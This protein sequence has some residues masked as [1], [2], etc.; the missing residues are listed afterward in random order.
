[1]DCAQN[2]DSVSA[3][4]NVIP[5][6]LA[7]SLM[8]GIAKAFD[9][10]IP[11]IAHHGDDVAIGGEHVLKALYGDAFTGGC[12]K[13]NARWRWDECRL[14]I[15]TQLMNVSLGRLQV[16]S[17]T[18]LARCRN[19]EVDAL[20]ADVFVQLTGESLKNVTSRD[21]CFPSAG[22]KNATRNTIFNHPKDKRSHELIF[23]SG[24]AR[25]RGG[26]L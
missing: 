24:E 2:A 6:E 5:R 12:G 26:R 3:F 9:A 16:G 1:M 8:C 17:H 19:T 20:C 21:S 18:A 22:Y 23:P 14:L 10:C 25:H 15:Q 4:L 13:G 11:K 7:E